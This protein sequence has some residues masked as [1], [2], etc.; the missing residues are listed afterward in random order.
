MFTKSLNLNDLIDQA[1]AEVRDLKDPGGPAAEVHRLCRLREQIEKA[2]KAVQEKLTQSSYDGPMGPRT[3][4]R[5]DPE[6]DAAALLRGEDLATLMAPVE[7]SQRASLL[8]QHRAANALLDT[9]PDRIREINIK[10]AIE[11]YGRIKPAVTKVVAALLDKYEELLSVLEAVQR[12][13][14]ELNRKGLSFETRG[15]L[16]NGFD[17]QI[18]GG[19]NGRPTLRWWIDKTRAE[20]GLA[21]DEKGR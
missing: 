15:P 1:L 6:A 11:E 13:D 4:T 5:H 2:N 8:R 7:E 18:L 21:T 20:W 3:L 17:S 10:V 9:L 16:F 19:G 14:H 12:F